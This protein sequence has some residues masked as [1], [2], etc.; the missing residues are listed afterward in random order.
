MAN[1]LTY[2][3]SNHPN[4]YSLLVSILLV[5]WYNGAI[6]VINFLFPVRGLAISILLILIPIT[7]F[8]TDDGK[9]DEMHSSDTTARG[10]STADDA[11]SRR[12]S[13]RRSGN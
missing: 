10:V 1:F 5:M 13:G 2:C 8:L 7:V 3:K 11:A 6:G 4:I 9:L 12:N